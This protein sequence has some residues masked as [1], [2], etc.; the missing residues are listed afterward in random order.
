MI[1]EIK[2]KCIKCVHFDT[3]AA[4]GLWFCKLNSIIEIAEQGLSVTESTNPNEF[5]CDDYEPP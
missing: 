2:K 4:K 5:F 3:K 1:S